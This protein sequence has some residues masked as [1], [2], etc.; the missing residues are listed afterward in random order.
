[1]VKLS[2]DPPPL[3]GVKMGHTA[4]VVR[5]RSV[6]KLNIDPLICGVKMEHTLQVVRGRSVIKLNTDPS[7]FA[8]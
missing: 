4:Y 1:M 7:P 5:G 3:C 2:I 6:V 8:G